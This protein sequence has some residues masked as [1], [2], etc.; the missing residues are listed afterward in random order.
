[1]LT[2]Q[3]TRT[4]TRGL[5]VG[6]V[7]STLAGCGGGVCTGWSAIEISKKD[8]MTQGTER[9]ILK[10]NE[11]GESLHCSAFKPKG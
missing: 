11:Y 8:K 2:R 3:A 10:H 4:L 6:V 1:V 9:Q 7:T 5:I